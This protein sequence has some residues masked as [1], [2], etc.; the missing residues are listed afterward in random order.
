M[1]KNEL[2]EIMKTLKAV[3][4]HRSTLDELVDGQYPFYNDY[5]FNDVMGRVERFINNDNR[6]FKGFPTPSEIL[7]EPEHNYPLDL[8]CLF[9]KI[10]CGNVPYNLLTPKEKCLCPENAFDLLM[11]FTIEERLNKREE[12]LD[13]LSNLS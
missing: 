13:Y 5:D 7:A 9:N 11:D 12:F 8:R 4:N 10:Y 6:S 3:Y 1:N 2:K